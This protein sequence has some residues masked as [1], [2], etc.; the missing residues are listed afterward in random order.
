MRIVGLLIVLTIVLIAMGNPIVFFN[1]PSIICTVGIPI[2]ALL[3]AGVSIPNL[4]KAIFSGQATPQEL[5][6]AAQGWAQARVYIVAAG[7]IGAIIGAILIFANIGEDLTGL[8]PAVAVDLITILYGVT[9]GYGIFLPLQHRLE[10]RAR[11][12]ELEASP[13]N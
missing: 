13:L 10:D 3:L 9:L 8:G 1:V 4:F 7:I 12:Q 11:E 5:L 2:G 6:A